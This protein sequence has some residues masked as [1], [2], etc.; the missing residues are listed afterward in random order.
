MAREESMENHILTLKHLFLE[1]T[2]S[3]FTYIFLIELNHMPKIK[4]TVKEASPI[5]PGVEGEPEK[6]MH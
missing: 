3:T 1:G 4:D 6:L 2:H 5:Y